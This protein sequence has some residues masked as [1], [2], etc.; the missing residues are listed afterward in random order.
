MSF[1]G[2]EYN[3][4]RFTEWWLNS[5]ILCYIEKEILEALMEMKSRIYFKVSKID[6]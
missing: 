4:D 5:L 2:Y 6:I 3:Q 1:F